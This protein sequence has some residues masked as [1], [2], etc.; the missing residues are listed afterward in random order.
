[1]NGRLEFELAL[2]IIWII[3]ALELIQHVANVYKFLNIF[4]QLLV[5]LFYQTKGVSG[6]S[7]CNSQ[8]GKACFLRWE[9]RGNKVNLLAVER[10]RSLCTFWKYW[11]RKNAMV[12]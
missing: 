4:P 7:F 10:L 12:P 6:N 9:D 5:M 1:M 8:Q 11:K 2:F 3:F